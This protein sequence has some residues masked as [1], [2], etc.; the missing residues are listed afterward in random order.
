[1]D[2]LIRSQSYKPDRPWGIGCDLLQKWIE[3][4]DT[5][6]DQENLVHKFC[7]AKKKIALV[8]DRRFW[9]EGAFRFLDLPTELRLPVY[10]FLLPPIIESAE[11]FEC[12]L[13]TRKVRVR[14]DAVPAL[15]M[16]PNKIG[17]SENENEMVLPF[18]LSCKFIQSEVQG[19][20][21]KRFSQRKYEIAVDPEMIYWHGSRKWAFKDCAML[22]G[23][24]ECI[25]RLHLSV[26]LRTDS[27]SMDQVTTQMET[28]VSTLRNLKHL[29]ELDVVLLPYPRWESAPTSLLLDD[30]ATAV[31]PLLILKGIE[32]ATFTVQEG[33]GKRTS[34]KNF[35][36]KTWI[37]DAPSG[38][39]YGMM[40]WIFPNRTSEQRWKEIQAEVLND[41]CVVP[42]ELSCLH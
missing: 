23:P 39:E 35:H 32:H 6:E 12:F 13:T 25:Q 33:A 41:V 31:S 20:I 8:L 21:W 37:P 28:L 5:L 15:P 40:G 1:V 11:D 10:R 16:L 18:L 36:V 38:R 2:E 24:F 3:Q 14:T 29:K 19:E 9:R 17:Q 27:D 4:V 42:T 22:R 34:P 26:Y 7:L 30:L